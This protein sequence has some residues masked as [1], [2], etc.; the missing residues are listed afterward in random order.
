MKAKL[1]SE[2][3]I[4][5]THSRNVEQAKLQYGWVLVSRT[6]TPGLVVYVR[7]EMVDMA[8][9]DHLVR[10]V[11]DR[12]KVLPGYLYTVLGS[13]VGRGLLFG[14]VHGSIQLQLPPDYITRIEIP[15]VP[16][17]SQRPIDDLIERYGEALTQASEFENRA[18][19][20]LAE[21]LGLGT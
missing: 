12:S 14:A 1:S 4:S 18:Q 13:A 21:A 6:G 15:I 8:G 20:L 11:S 16:L 2:K 10:L 7:R 3:Y 9:S 17:E 5:R 19:M